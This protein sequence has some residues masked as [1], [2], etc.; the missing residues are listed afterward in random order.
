VTMVIRVANSMFTRLLPSKIVDNSRSGWS[1]MA[2]TRRAPGF[3]VLTRCWS[4]G[5]PCNE[6]NAASELEK[7]ADRATETAITIMFTV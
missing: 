1:S 5:D 6:R 4:R 2:D 7:K 3:P